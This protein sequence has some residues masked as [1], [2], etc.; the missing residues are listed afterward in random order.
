MEFVHKPVLFRETIAGLD[1]RPDGIYLDGTAG[2]G[3]HSA[4]IASQL[5]GGRLICVDQDPDAI[6]ILHERLGGDPHVTIVQ[7]NFS[8]M[9]DI[10][11]RLALPPLQTAQGEVQQSLKENTA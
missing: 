9:D 4:A 11:R 8:R 10:A 6:E 2:G 3:G 1:V 5:R 7:D